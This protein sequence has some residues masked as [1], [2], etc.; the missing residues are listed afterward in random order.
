MTMFFLEPEERKKKPRE[1]SPPKGPFTF[2]MSSDEPP[3][4]YGVSYEFLDD[5]GNEI[6]GEV[7]SKRDARNVLVQMIE[8]GWLQSESENEKDLLAQIASAEL[9]E[10]S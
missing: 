6:H 8:Q 4:S 1:K 7:L 9:L 5:D 3:G 10:R 2:E